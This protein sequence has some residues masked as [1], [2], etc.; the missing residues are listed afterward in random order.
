MP[1]F[2]E[3]ID[4]CGPAQDKCLTEVWKHIRRES[5]QSFT[6]DCLGGCWRIKHKTTLSIAQLLEQ[7]PLIKRTG[8][9]K[10]NLAVVHAY[11][12]DA[13]VQSHKTEE[14]IGFTEFLCKYQLVTYFI[15]DSHL[16]NVYFA[17]NTGG[18]LGNKR[19]L[20]FT[21]YQTSKFFS[22]IL[23]RQISE[24]I[25]SLFHSFVFRIILRFQCGIDYRTIIFYVFSAILHFLT[26]QKSTPK[27][28]RQNI[29][30][31]ST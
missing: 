10:S 18:L 13:I 15:Q 17:A 25:F 11:L 12:L 20:T 2:H 9:S 24:N 6:C 31:I 21:F 23:N 26:I 5:N 4:I 29:T 27:N 16:K 7:S 22:D 19:N 3:N 1:R 30:K 28:I 8:L 14:Y